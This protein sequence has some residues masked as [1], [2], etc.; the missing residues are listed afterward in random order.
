M[1]TRIHKPHQGSVRY[2]ETVYRSALAEAEIFE[3]NDC[4]PALIELVPRSIA[5]QLNA[6][7]VEVSAKSLRVDPGVIDDFLLATFALRTLGV[8]W[9]DRR[10]TRLREN[11]HQR[12]Q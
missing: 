10:L 9:D 6:S 12:A 7:G 1:R 8:D 2:F 4:G 11:P 5:G 3:I